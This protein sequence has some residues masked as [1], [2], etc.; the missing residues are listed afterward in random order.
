MT[1]Y[2]IGYARISSNLLIRPQDVPYEA[3]MPLRVGLSLSSYP[4]QLSLL[5]IF[6]VDLPPMLS[7]MIDARESVVTSPLAS[8]PRTVEENS[9]MDGLDVPSQICLAAK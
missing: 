6:V 7:Q 1:R 4:L 3:R 2:T 9:A 5:N 8:T